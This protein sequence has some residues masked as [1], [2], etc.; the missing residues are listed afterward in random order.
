MTSNGDFY[1]YDYGDNDGDDDDG[2]AFCL[3]LWFKKKNISI[4]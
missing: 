1:D 2:G 4:L 3:L